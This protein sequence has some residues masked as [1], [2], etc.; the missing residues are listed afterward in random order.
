[1]DTHLLR[2]TVEIPLPSD[3][4]EQA[5]ILSKLAEPVG[6]LRKKLAAQKLTD[7]KYESRV[8]RQR[9]FAERKPKPQPEQWSLAANTV[10]D[11]QAAE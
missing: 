10:G 9:E 6:E 1:V 3:A 2:I 7:H 8:I 4:I 5:A 11:S